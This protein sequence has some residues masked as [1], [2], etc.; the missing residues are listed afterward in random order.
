VF[1]GGVWFSPQTPLGELLAGFL[2][3]LHGRE[4]RRR[5]KE[6][7]EGRRGDGERSVPLL[8]LQFNN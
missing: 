5:G 1:A 3:P 2:G 4:G 8:S 6:E 7:L